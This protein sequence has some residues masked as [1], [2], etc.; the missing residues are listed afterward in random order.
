MKKF[1]I[2]YFTGKPRPSLVW[3]RNGHVIDDSQVV[4]AQGVV[5]NELAITRLQRTDL[6]A[7]LTCSASNS[8][9]SDPVT[10]TVMLDMNCELTIL[11][12][13]LTQFPSRFN[14]FFMRVTRTACLLTVCF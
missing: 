6:A 7:E 11:S 4:T 1:F 14:Y 3:T 2:L 12:L 10:S 13:S 5:R 8:N 9:F